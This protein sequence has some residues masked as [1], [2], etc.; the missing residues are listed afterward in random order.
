LG[1]LHRVKIWDPV[2]RLWHWV[3]AIVVMLGWSFGKFMSFSTIQW[4]FYCGY[5]I[6]GLLIFRYLWGFAGPAPVRYRALLPT[7]TRTFAYLK[8]FGKRNPSGSPG[9]NPLGSLSIIAMMLL[10]TAQATSGLFIVSDDFFESAPLA[11]LVSD[12]VSNRLT[13]WHKLISKF[14]LVVVG[15]HVIAIF[16]YLL[17]KKENLIKPMIT[18][19]KWVRSAPR[20]KQ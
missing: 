14:I 13:W 4:H 2:T 8:E 9:H 19:W 5:T 10:L 7:P 3:L 12:A 20:P 15:L 1:D 6:I 11:H 16:Y 18:G 17:W